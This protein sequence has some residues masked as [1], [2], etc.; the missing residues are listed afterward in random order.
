MAYIEKRK[1]PSGKIGYRARVRLDGAPEK[2]ETFPTRREAETWSR[3][4]E[5]EIKEGRYF[6]RREDKEK[7]FIEFIERYIN[8]EL[9]KNPRAYQ[10]QK[11]LLTWWTSHLGPYYLCHITPSIIA[12]LRDKLMSEST[13]RKKLRTPSTAN[14][15]LASLSRAFNIAVKEWHWIKENPVS[16]IRRPKENKPKERYLNKEEIERLL[17]ACHKS[18][19]PHIYPVVLFALSTGARKG[20]I[21]NL[22]WE[23]I[24][25][26]R[27]TATFRDTKNG[28]DHTVYINKTLAQCLMCEQ[29][30][31]IV[32]SKYVFPDSSGLR[33]ADIRTAWERVVKDAELTKVTL[34]TLRHTVGSF[35]ALSGYSTLEIGKILN[36]KCISMVKRYSHLST[37]STAQA[38][39]HMNEQIFSGYAYG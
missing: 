20:E 38:L 14:R 17:N 3:K 16:R 39:E 28:S 11:Q 9:P 5:S 15:Y 12:E 22:L 2:T 1:Y 24:D 27:S 13:S 7:T 33:P 18:K 29:K 6:G 34:H 31:R 36:H 30:K 37:S 26:D 10:K 25:F 8:K 35:L 21:L 4:M 32:F 23:D 19:S